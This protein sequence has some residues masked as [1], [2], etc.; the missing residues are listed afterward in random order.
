MTMIQDNALK[1]GVEKYGNSWSRIASD[2]QLN[3]IHRTGQDL[4]DRCRV[5]FPE[6]YAR[7]IKSR[8]SNYIEQPDSQILKK[9]YALPFRT[10]QKSESPDV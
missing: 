3:L 7:F 5:A 2:Q 6:T 1:L 9:F 4:R 8:K 10:L